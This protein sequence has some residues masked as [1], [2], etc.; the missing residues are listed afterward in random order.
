MTGGSVRRRAA[1]LQRP[2]HVRDI[3]PLRA[4]PATAY[5]PAVR[6]NPKVHHR[7][8]VRLPTFDYRQAGAYFVTICTLGRECI[9]DID[10]IRD[11]LRE[12]W[13]AVGKYARVATGDE[14]I[15][16]PNHVHGIIWLN[17]REQSP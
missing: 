14:F 6:Y 11:A 7:R 15:V 8:S 4:T 3:S 5:L 10:S 1:P 9:L 16:M 2:A 12:T 17:R 13:K